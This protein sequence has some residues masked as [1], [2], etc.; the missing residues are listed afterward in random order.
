MFRRIVASK[1]SGP[2]D[3]RFSSSGTNKNCK[4]DVIQTR[5]TK[6]DPSR[7]CLVA[8]MLVYLLRADYYDLD[9]LI[10]QCSMTSRT[11]KVSTMSCRNNQVII[12]L[13]ALFPSAIYTV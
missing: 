12:E 8:R 1:I 6:F 9:L 4:C 10:E 5:Q 11:N 3:N 13:P 7:H 2:S